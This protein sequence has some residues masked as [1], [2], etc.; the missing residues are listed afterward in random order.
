MEACG[1]R[2]RS[3]TIDKVPT[4]KGQADCYGSVLF[5]KNNNLANKK[6]FTNLFFCRRSK[7]SNWEFKESRIIPLARPLRLFPLLML[8]HFQPPLLLRSC[9]DSASLGYSHYALRTCVTED[10]CC[11]A[12][13]KASI[14]LICRLQPLRKFLKKRPINNTTHKQDDDEEESTVVKEYINILKLC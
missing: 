9:T 12:T 14:P 6:L 11:V 10:G 5:K 1:S 13:W 4:N 3:I 8:H 7:I 2:Q